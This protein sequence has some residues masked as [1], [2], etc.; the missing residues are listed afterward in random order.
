MTRKLIISILLLGLNTLAAMAQEPRE[1][2]I[3]GNV[4]D[5]ELKEP[6]VQATVQL[7][8]AKDSSFVG[9]TVTDL[10]GNFAL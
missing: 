7:F 8:W 5:A 9:G 4:E 6:M 1:R 10:R 2:T 3:S